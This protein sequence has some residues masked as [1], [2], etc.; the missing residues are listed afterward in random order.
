MPFVCYL[1]EDIQPLIHPTNLWVPSTSQ[2]I[3]KGLRRLKETGKSRSLI[4]QGPVRISVFGP[5]GGKKRKTLKD[6]TQEKDGINLI[7]QQ[8]PPATRK[9]GQRGRD[10][11]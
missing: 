8:A 10:R 1:T 6:L 9:T 7:L 3:C 4:Q 5:R 11:T 2:A